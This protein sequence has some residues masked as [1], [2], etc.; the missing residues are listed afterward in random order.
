MN[1]PIVLTSK[2]CAQCLRGPLFGLQFLILQSTHTRTLPQMSKQPVA[3]GKDASS[4]AK[5]I[6]LFLPSCSEP[7]GCGVPLHLPVIIRVL[8]EV[9][10]KKTKRQLQLLS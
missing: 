2:P 1:A 10:A 9:H 3:V 6:G 4:V 5:G 7:T 8:M